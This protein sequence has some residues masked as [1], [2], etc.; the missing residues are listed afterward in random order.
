MIYNSTHPPESLAYFGGKATSLLSL[1]KIG[2]NIPEFAVIPSNVLENLIP[3]HLPMDQ[4]A[5]FITSFYFDSDFFDAIYQA[6]PKGCH[7]FAVRSSGIDE[8]GRFFSFAGQFETELFVKREFLSDAIK[9]V[10]KSAYSERITV[11][12]QQNNF[13]NPPAIAVIIQA[14]IHA[15]ASGVAFTLNPLTGDDELVVNAVYGLGE[16][17]V[18]GELEADMF[19]VRNNQISEQ[20]T[21]KK[22]SLVFDEY[23][24]TGT[25]YMEVPDEQ[26][27]QPCLTAAQILELANAA[28]TLQEHYQAPQDIEFCFS[29]KSLFILQSRP[30]TTIS[31]EP[32]TIWDN[33]NIVES[34]P[35]LTSPLTFSFIK[36]MYAAVYRQLSLIMGIRSKKIED[37]TAVFENMLGLL[38]GRVYYNLNN[39]HAAL[40]LL[41][42]YE[43]N[44]SF[45]DKMMGVKEKFPTKLTKQNNKLNEVYDVVRAIFSVLK[46]HRNMNKD[47]KQ[48]LKHFHAVLQV[49]EQLDFDRMSLQELMDCYLEFENTLSKNWRA[50][51]VND[52]FCMVYFGVL[53]KL[54]FKYFGEEEKDLHN[55]LLTGAK[56]I[57]ST[58]P[59]E[60]TADIVQEI[61]KNEHAV[62][63]FENDSPAE[64]WAKLQDD[65]FSAIR[66]KIDCYLKKWGARCVGELKLETITYDQCPENFISILK[67]YIQNGQTHNQKNLSG[68]NQ[69]REKAEDFVN[70]RLN[71]KWVKR[72]IFKFVLKK[73][74]YLVSNRENLRFERT[75]GFG[76]VRVMMLSFGKKFAHAGI[77]N[78]ER[79]IFY[80][81][82]HEIFDFVNGTSIHANFFDLIELRRKIYNQFE[83]MVLSER[84]KGRGNVYKNLQNFAFKENESK[85]DLLHGI[86]CCPGI[87]EGV[88]SVLRSPQEIDQLN[89]NILVTSS[90]DPG[91][92]VLFP[93]A[94]A[95]VVE[96]GS[97]LSHSAIVSREM[98]IPCIVGVKGLLNQVKSGDRIKMNGATGQIEILKRHEREKTN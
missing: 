14:M 46:T 63:L 33:S 61:H 88:V 71:G 16:G 73:T 12:R 67:S 89:G 8:D 38:W 19:V 60:W 25:V 97:L 52:F 10:W 75:K 98:G 95:I 18:S 56:D 92:V 11:Y 48:F 54:C 23:K 64:L 59:I 9:R 27:N 47:R 42:G 77:I 24:G 29:G 21:E 66:E 3:K 85:V 17:L 30:I 2:V 31:N 79:D 65:S 6:L 80:L 40:A 5:D 4:Y 82:Q 78:Y 37:Q 96:R 57:I 28:A 83:G 70:Q 20:I 91:W 26:I 45:M 58:E 44:A 72:L 41:P 34:Y 55:N 36:K 74:R 35:G 69:V 81:T 94:T 1:L 51:I 86:P 7:F 76:M 84:I 32:F 43:L 87:V 49:Y 15:D 50:P 68:H 13:V 53:Q 22:L 93:K 39:W 62:V 90:T